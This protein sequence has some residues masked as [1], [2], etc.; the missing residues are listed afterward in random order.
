MALDES[1]SLIQE[2]LK[3]FQNAFDQIYPQVIPSLSLSALIHMIAVSTF[4]K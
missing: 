1:M 2:K 3:E 4:S